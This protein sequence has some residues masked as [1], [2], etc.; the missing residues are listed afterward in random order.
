MASFP[1]QPPRRAEPVLVGALGSGRKHIAVGDRRGQA[2]LQLAEVPL[3]QAAGVWLQDGGAGGGGG[4]AMVGEAVA[5][6]QLLPT[7]NVAGQPPLLVGLGEVNWRRPRHL[8]EVIHEDRI[9]DCSGDEGEHLPLPL[10]HVLQSPVQILELELGPGLLILEPGE[11]GLEFALLPGQPIDLLVHGRPLGV[12]AARRVAVAVDG[13]PA[14]DVLEEV[15]LALHEILVREFPS[16]RIDL[17][18]S[19]PK[20]PS[21]NPQRLSSPRQIGS[22]EQEISRRLK[23]PLRAGN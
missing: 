4:A 22:E 11:L 9:L 12:S 1:G 10:L 13:F 3:E 8:D 7:F 21:D 19:L 5:G 2:Q 14:V 6:H 17:P 15:L 23:I 16:L 18:E 20:K